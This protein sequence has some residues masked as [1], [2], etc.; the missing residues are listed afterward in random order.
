MFQTSKQIF[1]MF[2]NKFANFFSYNI[3]SFLC[4]QHTEGLADF[5]E[6]LAMIYLIN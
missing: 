2:V 6:L 1:N 4:K 5:Y 3:N